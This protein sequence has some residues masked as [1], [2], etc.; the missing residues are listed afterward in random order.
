MRQKV[1]PMKLLM[2]LLVGIG[3]AYGAYEMKTSK[4]IKPTPRGKTSV[5]SKK[6]SPT[7]YEGGEGYDKAYP[8]FIATK[9]PAAIYF[10]TDW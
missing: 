1:K 9:A 3:L 2:L 4:A 7:W 10:Y 8:E 6:V 5:S